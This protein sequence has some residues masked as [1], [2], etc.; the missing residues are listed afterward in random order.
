[1]FRFFESIA[2]LDNTPR[3]LYFHQLRVN[4]T[5]KYFYPGFEPFHLEYIIFNTQVNKYSKAKLKFS[6][7]ETSYKI[8]IIQYVAKVFNTFHL[9]TDN[10]IEY[11]FKFIDRSLLD[12]HLKS[13][14]INDQIMI[15][16]NNLITDTQY[17]NLVFFDGY[18]WLT[19]K[20]PLLPGTMRASLLADW[21]I[22][23]EIIELEH[24]ANFHSFKLINAMNTLEESY[25][26][27]MDKIQ[28][29]KKH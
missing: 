14:P 28:V 19:P 3:N 4:K 29:Q 24:F 5:F 27:P 23:E 10:S 7:N 12:N 1:M 20:N 26:Y 11:K 9:I 18:R 2:I 6:Y 25:E 17:S 22:H 21:K 16:K 13:Y 15:I 8:N